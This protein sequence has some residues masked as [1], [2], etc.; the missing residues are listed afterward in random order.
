MITSIHLKISTE[1]IIE[2]DNKSK[3]T[4]IYHIDV[5]RLHRL[6]DELIFL[7]EDE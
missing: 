5:E 6:I 7:E 3:I 1:S 2:Y 4:N